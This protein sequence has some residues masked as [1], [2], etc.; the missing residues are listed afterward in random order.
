MSA[1]TI[2][3]DSCTR[4]LLGGEAKSHLGLFP[5]PESRKTIC[6]HCMAVYR[7]LVGRGSTGLMVDFLSEWEPSTTGE[8]AARVLA[9]EWH[10]HHD[11]VL[12][13]VPAPGPDGALVVPGVS[14]VG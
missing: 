11:G 14:G 4:P 3:C 12:V 2:I 5:S 8:E 6:P 9:L 13:Q 7:H 1:T 10:W